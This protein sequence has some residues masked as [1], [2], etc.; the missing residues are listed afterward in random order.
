LI[1]SS[2]EFFGDEV[3][4]RGSIAVGIQFWVIVMFFSSIDGSVIKVTAE[5]FYGGM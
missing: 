4:R 1:N 2:N 5:T 3:F